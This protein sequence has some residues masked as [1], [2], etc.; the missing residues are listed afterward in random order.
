M[1]DTQSV[2]VEAFSY[3][4]FGNTPKGYVCHQCGARGVKLWREYNT[5]L[6]HQ[7][8]LCVKCAGAKNKRSKSR[9]NPKLAYRYDQLFGNLNRISR[10]RRSRKNVRAINRLRN[11]MR[12]L[13][14]KL[15]SRLYEYMT[16]TSWGDTDSLGWLVPAV[17]TEEGDTYWGYTSVP[18]MGCLWW[19]SLKS[20]DWTDDIVLK[21][22][23]ANVGYIETFEDSIHRTDRANTTTV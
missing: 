19:R 11:E 20:P 22:Y 1:S 21:D 15:G 12:L 8:L 2:T 10:H 16:P 5:F 9:E 14:E 4:D 17:P 23:K 3:A 18:A 7:T 6:D 13:D